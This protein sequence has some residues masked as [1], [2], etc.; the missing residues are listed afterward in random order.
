M[1]HPHE[2]VLAQVAEVPCVR[3]EG[4][5]I[6]RIHRPEQGIVGLRIPEPPQL[7]QPEARFDVRR[8]ELEVVGHHV[9]I[10]A[11]API[12]VQPVQLAI[13]KGKKSAD[14]GIARLAVTAFGIGNIR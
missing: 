2:A 4:T 14:D 13:E 1:S 12:G 3:P 7:Q 10:G 9:T 8:R 6:I 11:G 5:E